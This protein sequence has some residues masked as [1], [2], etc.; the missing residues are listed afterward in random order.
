MLGPCG[1]CGC[2]WARRVSAGGGG[3]PGRCPGARG[4][5]PLG[6]GGRWGLP[7]CPRLPSA[8]RCGPGRGRCGPPLPSASLPSPWRAGR[9]APPAPRLAGWAGPGWAGMPTAGVCAP[10]CPLPVSPQ[11]VLAVV[12]ALPPGV[13]EAGRP[14]GLAGPGRDGS[15]AALGVGSPWAEAGVEAAAGPKGLR[16]RWYSPGRADPRPFSLPRPSWGGGGRRGRSGPSAGGQAGWL[17]WWGRGGLWPA[18]RRGPRTRVKS[19]GPAWF[20]LVS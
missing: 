6:G 3:V 18:Q 10:P 8:A 4:R 11:G 17:G 2:C 14:E 12:P 5:A 16:R 20:H 9:G 13:C 19:W 7:V 15:G 1:C